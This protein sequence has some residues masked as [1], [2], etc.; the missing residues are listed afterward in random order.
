MWNLSDNIDIFKI[1]KINSYGG[2]MICVN[3][4]GKQNNGNGQK[5]AEHLKCIF[6]KMKVLNFSDLDLH[7][8]DKCNYECFYDKKC[9]FYSDDAKKLYDEIL[10]EEFLV[11]VIPIYSDFPCSNYF[12]FR[13]RMQFYFTEELWCKFI[14][15]KKKFIIIGNTGI[16]NVLEVLKNDYDFE[17]YK[18]ILIL[19]SNEYNEKSYFGNLLNHN[20]VLKRI[21]GFVASD[22]M[23]KNF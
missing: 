11:F 23:D 13:E 3:F 15:I 20:D 4:S 17:Y 6:P 8:C 1:K 9:P 12:I 18:D 19:S 22:F 7:P 5:I 10:S 16:K 2:F 14:K 21:D